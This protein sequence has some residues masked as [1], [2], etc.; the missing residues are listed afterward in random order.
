MVNIWRVGVR[1]LDYSVFSPAFKVSPVTPI[2]EANS[3]SCP[4]NRR[5]LGS[6]DQESEAWERYEAV[7]DHLV[8][9]FS[10]ELWPKLS[11]L[12]NSPSGPISLLPPLALKILISASLPHQPSSWTTFNIS[13]PNAFAT[14]AWFWIFFMQFQLTVVTNLG[15]DCCRLFTISCATNIG[16]W[17]PDTKRNFQRY[18]FW[19]QITG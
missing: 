3:K 15:E 5:L 11:H 14:V 12:R 2:F 19:L 18:S 1:W 4:S 13:A 6:L 8:H 9:P 16:L 17:S 7:T 10:S